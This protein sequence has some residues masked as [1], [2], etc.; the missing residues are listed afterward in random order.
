[1]KGYVLWGVSNIYSVKT[2]NG[3]IYESRL[4]GKVL[5]STV[6]SHNALVS[7]DIVEIQDIDELHKQAMISSQLPR[8][9]SF[10]RF[11]L[12]TRSIQTIVANI[13]Q[14][15]IVMSAKNPSFRSQFLDRALVVAYIENIPVIIVINKQDEGIKLT[16]KPLIELYQDNYKLL[17]TSALRGKGISDLEFLLKGKISAVFGQ[18]GVGKS[19]LV[20]RIFP[21]A[22]QK[23]CEI[24]HKYNR[25][26]HTTVYSLMFENSEFQLIDTPGIKEFDLSGVSFKQ[27]EQS[28]QEIRNL[29]DSCAFSNCTH[30]HEPKCAVIKSYQEGKIL[31]KRMESY[32][33]LVGYAN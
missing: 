1:M 9:N 32:W 22:N 8:K 4:K 17:F 12:K 18:S 3:Q 5:E 21:Q 28:F 10:W 2:E 7:G 26:R 15:I 11:N 16:D 25:G 19:T 29:S 6:R 33:A 13:D 14:V 20:N 23:T 31:R 27:V 24:S 30:T